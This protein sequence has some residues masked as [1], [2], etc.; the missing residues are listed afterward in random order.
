MPSN[1]VTVTAVSQLNISDIMMTVN[2]E[3]V[4]SPVLSCE[5]PMAANASTAITVAPSNGIAV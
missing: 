4:Y 2:N 3:R 5:V 1:G